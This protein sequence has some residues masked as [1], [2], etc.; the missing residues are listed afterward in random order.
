MTAKEMRACMVNFRL[1]NEEFDRVF[2][3]YCWVRLRSGLPTYLGRLTLFHGDSSVGRCLPTH[4]WKELV[5]GGI[6]VHVVKGN[7]KLF[8]NPNLLALIG[9]YIQTSIWMRIKQLAEVRACPEARPEPAVA[10]AGVDLDPCSESSG[11]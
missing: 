5:K 2:G 9:N 3:D 11:R 8:R 6:E 10:A 1:H 4:D 7:H